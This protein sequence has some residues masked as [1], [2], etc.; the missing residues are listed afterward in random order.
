MH[1][2]PKSEPI[3]PDSFGQ[4]ILWREQK[5]KKTPKKKKN[6]VPR[7]SLAFFLVPRRPPASAAPPP[8]RQA[9][10]KP[11]NASRKKEIRLP[12]GAVGAALKREGRGGFPARLPGSKETIEGEERARFPQPPPPGRKQP[13]RAREDF[14][15]AGRP[16]PLLP[17]LAGTC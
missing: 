2:T 7:R 16:S 5:R 3:I 1:K 9:A 8:P 15:A 6:P 11:G 14:G 17:Y 4:L 13:R 10:M 12:T